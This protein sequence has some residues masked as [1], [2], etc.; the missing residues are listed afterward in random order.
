MGDEDRLPR[1]GEDHG[2]GLPMAWL[3]AVGDAIGAVVDRGAFGVA[4]PAPLGA[5][6]ALVFGA[7]EIEAPSPVVGAAQLIIDEAIDGLVA[8]D[9]VPGLAGK[10][11][12]D[13][14]GRP[15]FCEAVEDG[16]AQGVVTLQPGAGPAPG[17]GLRL[18]IGGPVTD[19]GTGV[20]L[21]LARDRRRLAIQSCSDLPDR[22]PGFM[23]PGNRTAFLD[24]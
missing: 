4:R 7:R 3:F 18:R 23:K 24:R 16:P 8:D 12:C 10:A 6:S 2:V 13:L 9:P 17:L 21:Q 19:L 14:L 5:P 22:L 15:A 20:A 11:A 1:C